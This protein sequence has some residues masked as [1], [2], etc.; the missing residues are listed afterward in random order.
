MNLKEKIFDWL[1]IIFIILAPLIMIIIFAMGLGK[2]FDEAV[3]GK[4]DD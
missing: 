1:V 4:Q 3:R 2:K